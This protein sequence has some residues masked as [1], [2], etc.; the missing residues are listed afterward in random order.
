MITRTRAIRM[1]EWAGKPFASEQDGWPVIESFDPPEGDC[2]IG[3]TDL[4]HRPKA[5]VQGAAVNEL[6]ML[7][8]GQVSWNGQAL[9]GL[10]KPQ[11]AVF[12]DLTGPMPST[13]PDDSYTEMSEGWVLLAIWG[14]KAA[15]VIQ[16]LVTVDIDPPDRLGP[17][18]FATGSHGLRVQLINLRGKS[19]GFLLA[20][21][22]SQAQNL[23]AACLR[24]GRQFDLQITGVKAF[25][26]WFNGLQLKPGADST[27][28]Q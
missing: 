28:G 1:P 2:E 23:F 22:R 20:G 8:P 10:S 24:A 19:P 27:N 5:I 26:E 9:L 15:E 4:S 21:D 25:Y 16:R 13:W 3:I 7:K 18:Y 11:Q 6:G 14:S 17:L 12:F